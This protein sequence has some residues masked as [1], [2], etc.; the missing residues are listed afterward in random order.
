M[1]RPRFDV[2]VPANGYHWWYFDA[3]SDDGQNGLTIIGFIG[4]V[5]SPYYRRARKHSE[6]NPESHCAINVALYG[7]SSRWAMTE[8]NASYLKRDAQNFT[9]GPSAMVW[10][11]TGLTIEIN[12]RCAPLPLNLS[13]KVRLR[14]DH[15]YDAP[16]ALDQDGKHFWQAVAPRSRVQV[17][18][19]K[20]RISW[21]GCAYHDMNWGVEPLEVGFKNW[22]WARTHTPSGTQVL[23]DVEHRDG[24]RFMFG[25]GFKDGHVTKREIPPLYE[26]KRGIWGMA[27]PVH[28]ETAPHLIAKLEDTPFY[29]RNQVAMTLDG[30]PCKAFHESLSLDRFVNT[31]VQRMLPFRMRRIG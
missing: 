16:I 23:Y 10:D 1:A 22:T 25:R 19:E 8:R 26:L 30:A 18:F 28:S 2:S 3:T 20:P 9:V 21:V 24:S 4:S 11:G 7:S 15:F 27:R 14:V 29:T 12:E 17:E 5:F 31:G 6:A 13:G